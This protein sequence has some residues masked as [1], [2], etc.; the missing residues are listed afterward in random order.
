MF[1]LKALEPTPFSYHPFG[2]QSS[3]L[4]GLQRGDWGRLST[5]KTV[6][7]HNLALPPKEAA[8]GAFPKPQ[9][10]PSPGCHFCLFSGLACEPV[11]PQ[12]G[13]KQGSD[14]VF[15]SNTKSCWSNF[16]VKHDHRHTCTKFMLHWRFQGCSHKLRLFWNS[17]YP[18]R[19]YWSNE[20]I[21]SSSV[22]CFLTY[23]Q[24][25]QDTLRSGVPACGLHVAVLCT[26]WYFPYGDTSEKWG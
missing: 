2:L 24:E 14:T 4:C 17:F 25:W 6:T 12:G 22:S 15:K 11:Q 23:H 26:P 7:E 16:M 8:M 13:L 21:M 10:S 20:R 1:I 18:S 19:Q 9:L 3:T 5:T